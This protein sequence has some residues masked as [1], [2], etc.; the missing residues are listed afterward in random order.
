[1]NTTAP[2]LRFSYQLDR[3]PPFN[4]FKPLPIDDMPSFSASIKLPH[5]LAGPLFNA[6]GRLEFTIDPRLSLKR[7]RRYPFTWRSDGQYLVLAIMALVNL[8]FCKSPGIFGK[9]FILSSYTLGILIPLTSQFVLPAT[10]IF[11]WLLLFWSGRYTIAAMKPHIWVSVLPTLESVLYGANI[12]D[13]LTRYTN[14][15]LDIVAWVPYGIIHFAFPFV[16]AALIWIFGPPGG[17]KFFAKVFGYLN[18]A[19]VMIQI[20]FPCTPPWYELLYGQTPAVYGMKGSPGGLA[21]ID[22]IFHSNGYTT[23]FTGAPMPF[24]AFP[25]LHAGC[26]TVDALLMNHFFPRYRIAYVCYVL[27]LYWS[28]MYL[29][30]HY[31]IDLVAGAALA[32]LSYYIF[33]NEDTVMREYGLAARL[34]LGGPTSSGAQVGSRSLRDA[35][36]DPESQALYGKDAAG[37]YELPVRDSMADDA[38]NA[39]DYADFEAPQRNN[40]GRSSSAAVLASGSNAPPRTDSPAAQAN[41][42][43]APALN[44]MA[45]TDSDNMARPRTPRAESTK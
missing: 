26:A 45:S 6:I 5:W 21:R 12:S 32:T 8:Y 7:I 2:L 37:D 19:G 30:H 41:P 18:V 35:D 40:T 36:M 16:T 11:S 28:T 13:I 34:A 27:W 42:F 20:L 25:S 3:T 29:T 23:T 1:M 39:G 4:A 33:V 10:P 38:D 9:L 44:R 43:L 31:L 17:V 22:A 24:A 14:S 15:F